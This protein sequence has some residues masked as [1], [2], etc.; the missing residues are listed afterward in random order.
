MIWSVVASGFLLGIVSN[1]HCLGMCGPIAMSIPIQ[2][3]SN[4]LFK[5]KI[6]GISLYN[7]GRL[8]SY[9]F[10]GIFAG[11]IGLS[12]QFIGFLQI[13]SV[14]I[15]FIIIL[16]AWKGF[17]PR[18]GT[19]KLER[20][21]FN[22]I[23]IQ[24]K[25]LKKSQSKIRIFFFGMLNGILPCGMVYLALLNALLAPSIGS[26]S[27]AMVSFGIGTLP[28]MMLAAFFG[29]TLQNKF[30][31]YKLLVP[32]LVTFIGFISIMR[33]ANLGIPMLSPKKDIIVSK[34]NHTKEINQNIHEVKPAC[35][36]KA[37]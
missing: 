6:S 31:R 34:S 8:S 2:S 28:I 22:F 20:S 7:F 1:I 29:S 15:G 5:S 26:S 17:I 37:K 10:L 12:I 4:G 33:G 24:F 11:I 14:I 36:R 21:I 19:N 25:K 35:C 23:S 3:K 16:Y 9:S 18:I 13:S 30:S 27:L 32:I